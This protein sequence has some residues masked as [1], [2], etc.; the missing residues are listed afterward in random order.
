[1]QNLILDERYKHEDVAVEINQSGVIGSQRQA[2]FGGSKRQEV[3][4]SITRIWNRLPPDPGCELVL[5]V[6]RCVSSLSGPIDLNFQ[7]LQNCHENNQSLG[8]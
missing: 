4:P 6:F 8:H 3:T 5:V 1:M 2:R 7:Q